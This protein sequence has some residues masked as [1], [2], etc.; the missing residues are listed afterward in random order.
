MSPEHHAVRNFVVTELPRVGR[1]LSIE[2]ISDRLQL[3][4]ERTL[5]I[6]DDLEEHRFFLVRRNG[7]E[8]SWAFPVTV[9]QTA[10]KLFFGTG[11]RLD[12]A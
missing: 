8:V 12:G 11:E 3:S 6:V 4:R 7:P 9:D 2:D 1:P 5:Q 10:H